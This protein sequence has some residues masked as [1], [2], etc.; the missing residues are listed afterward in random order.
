MPVPATRLA[1]VGARDPQPPVLRRGR[2]HPL[3]QLAIA[4]LELDLLLQLSPCDADTRRQ[5]V[6]DSLQIAQTECARLFGDRRN[7]G[8][9]S[10]TGKGIGDKRAELRFEAADLTPQLRPGE[11][12]VAI[13][14]NVGASR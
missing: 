14:E 6:A 2:E 8:V 9:E 4:G 10:Q 1:D 7:T 3:Q 11:P 12:L 5:G 13:D